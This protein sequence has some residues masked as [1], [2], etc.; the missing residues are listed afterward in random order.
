MSC[1]EILG[2]KEL[3]GT[4]IPQGSKN[5]ALQ[6]ICATLLT[7]EK[8]YLKN[9]PEIKDVLNLIS[10]L[11]ILGVRVKK[12]KKNQFLFE[13][14]KINKQYFKDQK[15]KELGSKIRGSIMIMGPLICRFGEAYVVK[16]GGDKIGRRPLDTHFNAFKETGVK[17][18]EKNDTYQLQSNKK[19]KS[20]NIT[21][22]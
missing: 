11:K 22:N 13:A 15:F 10:L 16:P 2:G 14:K 18:I 7:K 1:F 12:I 4:I 20:I 19:H 6:I 5:E 8:V 9:I 21:L 3:S 17:V